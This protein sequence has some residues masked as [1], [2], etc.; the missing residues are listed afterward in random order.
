[1]IQLQTLD[2]IAG[3]QPEDEQEPEKKMKVVSSPE[4]D[5][6]LSTY[7]RIVEEGKRGY[8]VLI[9]RCA[10]TVYSAPVI[11]KASIALAQAGATGYVTEFLSSLINA[12]ADPEHLLFT[13]AY[14]VPL[15]DVGIYISEGKIVRIYGPTGNSLGYRNEG[16][17]IAFGATGGFL[18]IA[19][20]GVVISHGV[21]GTDVG[22]RNDGIVMV[23][24][25]KPDITNHG[26]EGD[27]YH[28][29]TLIVKDGI[30]L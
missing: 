14:K 18:G 21:T 7:D 5:E 6:I 2:V 19:N 16:I 23:Y 9:P 30:L 13:S 10:S 12:S 8:G 3:L 11:T 28:N 25:P 22:F 27:I 20:R 4:L 1:M 15:H 17:I 24:G 26:G 29:G